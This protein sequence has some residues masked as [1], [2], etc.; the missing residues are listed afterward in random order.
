MGLQ[1]PADFSSLTLDNNRFTG[2]LPPTWLANSSITWVDVVSGVVRLGPRSKVQW[3]GAPAQKMRCTCLGQGRWGAAMGRVA[4]L[5]GAVLQ[6]NNRL[7]GSIPADWALPATLNANPATPCFTTCVGMGLY[8]NSFSGTLQCF[9]WGPQPQALVPGPGDLGCQTL[10][11]RLS[12]GRGGGRGLRPVAHGL[13]QPISAPCS[14][15]S[16]PR[17]SPHLLQGRCPC[18]RACRRRM[19]LCR[20]TPGCAARWVVWQ[21]LPRPCMLGGLV[22]R[23]SKQAGVAAARQRTELASPLSEK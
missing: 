1:L 19:S 15:P 23:T 4:P 8:N 11:G 2:T 13:L 12:C 6:G 10:L 5:A 21:P 9:S 16:Q 18:C 7:T 17:P 22:G 20:G 14:A 3:G